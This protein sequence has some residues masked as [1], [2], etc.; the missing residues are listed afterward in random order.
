MVSTPR[1]AERWCMRGPP[2]ASEN[3]ANLASAFAEQVRHLGEIA[4]KIAVLVLSKSIA[5]AFACWLNGGSV[6]AQTISLAPR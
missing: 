1:R 2:I 6:R 4:K 3:E 5:R